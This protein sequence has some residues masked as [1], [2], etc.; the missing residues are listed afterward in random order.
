M[1]EV[2]FVVKILVCSGNAGTISRAVA[3]DNHIC[4][5]KLVVYEFT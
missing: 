5:R 3:A 4:D 2:V 1:I